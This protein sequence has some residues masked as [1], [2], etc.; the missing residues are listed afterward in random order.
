[1]KKPEP[2]E[3]L[4]L[5]F[6]YGENSGDS[7]HAQPHFGTL[8]ISRLLNLRKCKLVITHSGRPELRNV[9]QFV[10]LIVQF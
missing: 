2:I 8:C 7:I 4:S 5:L 3:A 6:R 9:S 1:M 10:V